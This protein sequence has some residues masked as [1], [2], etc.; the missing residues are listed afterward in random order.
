[1]DTHIRNFIELE[2][3][4]P[5]FNISQDSATPGDINN[6][7][8]NCLITNQNARTNLIPVKP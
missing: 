6:V 8:P 1:M 3:V 2:I 4:N 5:V 7:I